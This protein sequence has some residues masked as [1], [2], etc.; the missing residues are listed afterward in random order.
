MIQSLTRRITHRLLVGTVSKNMEF[1]VPG[2]LN[3]V[4]RLMGTQIHLY[5]HEER[6]RIYVNILT[7][8]ISIQNNKIISLKQYIYTKL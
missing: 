3:T 4:Q 1:S 8:K 6:V 5:K 2:S 7:C